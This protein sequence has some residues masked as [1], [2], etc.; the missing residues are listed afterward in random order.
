MGLGS[1]SPIFENGEN[2]NRNVQHNTLSV[3]PSADDG[4][5]SCT[6]PVSDS[7]K[8]QEGDKSG[9]VDL[10][11]ASEIMGQNINEQEEVEGDEEEVEGQEEEE[12][13]EELTGTIQE[14][15][16]SEGDVEEDEDK[17]TG[18]RRRTDSYAMAMFNSSVMHHRRPQSLGRRESYT[19]A[20]KNLVDSVTVGQPTTRH[21][22]LIDESS[23]SN[24]KV[25]IQRLRIIGILQHEKA[26]TKYI[27]PLVGT[28][29]P[30]S[31]QHFASTAIGALNPSSSPDYVS[32]P[33]NDSPPVS[34][35]H[36]ASPPRPFHNTLSVTRDVAHIEDK[37]S[38][39]TAAFGGQSLSPPKG[40][41]V[42][43][44]NS[45]PLLNETNSASEQSSVSTRQSSQSFSTRRSSSTHEEPSD[46]SINLKLEENQKRKARRSSEGS[47]S[48]MAANV[49]DKDKPSVAKVSSS[50]Y[51][52]SFPSLN[53]SL[54]SEL[55]WLKTN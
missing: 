43:L 26:N 23:I 29:P 55:V 33:T 17:I 50:C 9:L 28:V 45:I 37:K 14:E 42:G 27:F 24:D 19:K 36:D 3:I 5:E 34:S 30:S 52:L 22:S 41:D 47:H 10:S 38:N 46:M 7:E 8:D 12:E 21:L 20:T 32:S 51:T 1:V 18:I 54:L 40:N 39:R 11:L 49:S 48:K 31:L 53:L 6:P 4:R 15:E 16:G 35:K 44:T 2:G 25:E 13:E